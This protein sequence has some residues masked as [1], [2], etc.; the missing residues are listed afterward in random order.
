MKPLTT[1]LVL[2]TLCFAFAAASTPAIPPTI[3]PA[4]APAP[5]PPRD[6]MLQTAMDH[7]SSFFFT[8]TTTSRADEVAYEL[9]ITSARNIDGK[10]ETIY[11]LPG[12]MRVFRADAD[13]DDFTKKGGWYW[14]IH[15]TQ[16]K[17]QLSKPG[18]LIMV[19]RDL[20]GTVHWHCLDLDI[21]C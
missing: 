3:P 10:P 4:T 18:A 11:V 17:S 15:D 16:G 2:T 6:E 8:E 13:R 19:I 5:R 21:R 12:S 1:L 7:P 14:K 9:I 20:D